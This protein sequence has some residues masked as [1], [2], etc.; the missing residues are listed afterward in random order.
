GLAW[1]DVDLDVR[2]I[3][4]RRGLQRRRGVGLV[5]VRPKTASSNRSVILSQTAVHALRQHLE[6]QEAERA[7][8]KNWRGCG[9]VFCT[10]AGGPMDGSRVLTALHRALQMADLPR[11]RVHELR[12][13]A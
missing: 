12:H 9:L 5:F 1:E 4:I 8:S 10:S 13:T 2:R 11:I 7:A 3:V 6:R